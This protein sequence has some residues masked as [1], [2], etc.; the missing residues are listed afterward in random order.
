MVTHVLLVP[1]PLVGPPTWQPVA[2]VLRSSGHAVT[3]VDTASVRRPRDLVATVV[4]AAGDDGPVV[5]VPHSNAGLAAPC[6][7][8][9]LD[10]EATVFVDAALPLGG[11]TFTPMAPEGLLDRLR[12]LADR[13]G[14]L[15]PWTEWWDDLE[16]V[17]PDLAT[18]AAVQ[19]AQPRL[20]LDYFTDRLPVPPGWT[21]W[22]TAYLAFGTTY[23]VEL[24]FAGVCGW[25]T[26]TLEGGHLHQLHD[27][28][29]VAASLLD[30]VERL[31]A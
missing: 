4:D 28:E 5:L 18:H 17:F 19:A 26:A 14:L 15:P 27:P 21:Q 13:D 22:P 1:S 16:G 8:E 25:P 7:A 29:A 23:S 2:G 12:S 6:L 31:R 3:V 10:L 9:S 30:L 20:H 24:A 11:S